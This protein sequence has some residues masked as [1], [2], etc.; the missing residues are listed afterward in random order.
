MSKK[1]KTIDA[2]DQSSLFYADRF[3]SYGVRTADIQR[4]FSLNKSGS[5][6]VLEL[7]C[8]NGRDACEIISEVGSENYVG[9]DASVSLIAI[10][11]VK[12][13]SGTFHVKDFQEYF[14]ENPSSQNSFGIILAFYSM[15]HVNREDLSLILA[16]CC[17]CLKVGGILYITS[18]YGDHREIEIE[19]LG[20]KKYYYSYKPEDLELAAGSNF[21]TVYKVINDTEYGPSFTLALRKV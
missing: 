1:Q 13:P 12:N 20:H 15:L 6:K 11:K 3:D 18:K 4:C 19:N 21:Q 10:A 7:G 14:V 2:Y 9:V 17:K 16:E 5:K 8:A